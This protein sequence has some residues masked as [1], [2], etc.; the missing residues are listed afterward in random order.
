ML[1]SCEVYGVILQF[2]NYPNGLVS[3]V[4]H[5]RMAFDKVESISNVLVFHFGHVYSLISVWY[6][7]GLE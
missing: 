4:I 7:L 3:I 6:L 5:G 1:P 2:V